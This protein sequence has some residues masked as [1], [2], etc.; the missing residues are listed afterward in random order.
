MP[1]DSRQFELKLEA[2]EADLALG[3]FP[4]AARHLRRQR[5]F[6][7]GYVTVVRND[8]PRFAACGSRAGFLRRA[9]Y[10]GDG[11]GDRPLRRTERR[12]AC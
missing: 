5:L 12:I 7:D 2:G 9:A 3:A 1:L 4:D 10:R 8:H 11:V 6:F